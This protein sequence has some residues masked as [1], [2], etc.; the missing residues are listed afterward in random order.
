MQFNRF[1]YLLS[2]Q[3]DENNAQGRGWMSEQANLYS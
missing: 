1:D 2:S 3:A